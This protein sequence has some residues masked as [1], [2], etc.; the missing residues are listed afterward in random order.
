MKQP[1]G[2]ERTNE[3]ASKCTDH[4]QPRREPWICRPKETPSRGSKGAAM[5]S[6]M[7]QLPCASNKTV[8][9][10]PWGEGSIT[11]TRPTWEQRRNARGN[12]KQGGKRW[13]T[14]GFAVLKTP[15]QA[16]VYVQRVVHGLSLAAY[17]KVGHWCTCAR[18]GPNGW[19]WPAAR[20]IPKASH[21]S[22]GVWRRLHTAGCGADLGET[23]ART[24]EACRPLVDSPRSCAP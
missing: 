19:P 8:R 1:L 16:D 20:R 7:P 10:P 11:T 5:P 2:T 23:E 24:T 21:I 4:D 9:P 14:S 22:C 12:C 15:T 17:Q 13:H 6:K 3:K 18:R